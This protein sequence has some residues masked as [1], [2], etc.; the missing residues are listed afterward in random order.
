[1][2]HYAGYPPNYQAHPQ[3]PYINPQGPGG[4]MP[5]PPPQHAGNVGSIRQVHQP[6]NQIIESEG[7]SEEEEFLE[8]AEL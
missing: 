1:M 2:G 8:R 5:Q 4:Y 3:G 6:W 7:E